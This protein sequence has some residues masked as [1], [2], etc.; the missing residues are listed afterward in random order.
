LPVGGNSSSN[1]AD[2]PHSSRKTI[3]STEPYDI[4]AYHDPIGSI[5]STSND[6]EYSHLDVMD[7]P[8]LPKKPSMMMM[9]EYEDN[10]TNN[11]NV[12]STADLPG[13]NANSTG[14]PVESFAP[15]DHPLE[16]IANYADLP[17]PEQL[18]TLNREYCETSGITKLIG[19]YRARCL[20]CKV[21]SVR[22]AVISKVIQL[23]KED[24]SNDMG[25]VITPL[26]AI[27][28]VGME[29]KIQQVLF[30]SINLL[31][32]VLKSAKQARLPR[33]TVTTALEH[34]L[35]QSVER[36]A[37]GNARLREGGRKTLDL[38]AAS[39]VIGCAAVQ[40]H[41][42]KTLP[43]KQKTAWRPVAARLQ[44]L[45]DLVNL[46]GVNNNAGLNMDTM[47]NFSKSNSV[48]A[49]SNGEVRDA[50]KA[51]V[52][53]IEKHVGREALES[54][55]ALLRKNQRDEYIAA[56]D[57]P[58]EGNN[59]NNNNVNANVSAKKPSAKESKE[60]KG[61][62]SSN[63]NNNNNNGNGSPSRMQSQHH[64]N[65]NSHHPGGKVP[66]TAARIQDQRDGYE[67]NQA[68]ESPNGPNANA[69]AGG[70]GQEFT[71]CMFCGVSD[72]H[73]T[74]ND[75]DLHYWKDC[76]LLIAC[77]SCSQIVEIAGLPEH[78]LDECD[79]RDSYEPCEV[80]GTVL[81]S[82]FF[83]FL[84]DCLLFC[85]LLGLAIKKEEL[86]NWLNSPKCVPAPQNYMYCPLCLLSVED[87]DAAWLQH[88]TRKCVKNARIQ[89][90]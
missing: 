23:L 43:P 36:L 40:Y 26:G 55:L 52:V 33:S 86:D 81:H 18:S 9:S 11:S 46:Y 89:R 83:V 16:G 3:K 76:P 78:L 13:G 37:D 49:H 31:E 62:P 4:P 74:E 27:L 61:G 66:T 79:A 85:L 87:S 41:L 58:P 90:S 84:F 54:T 12:N 30:N 42:V 88:L 56:F 39:S 77:P 10:S 38:L 34:V 53:A 45:A 15:G 44:V 29:D 72:P 6:A 1:G 7:R 64:H 24:F 80:T 57:A 32:Q 73:W 17:T 19:E 71:A 8:I 65:V 28:K 25:N 51:L 5:A 75:L 2:R 35:S 60:S 68:N 70:A 59:I 20:Y 22:E 47:L 69:A 67:T 63:N 82:S 48:Y 21:W 14:M 50:A